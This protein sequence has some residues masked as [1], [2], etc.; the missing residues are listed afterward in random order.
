MVSTRKGRNFRIISFAT[1]A[2]AIGCTIIAVVLT[3]L[4]IFTA[5]MAILASGTI[6]VALVKRVQIARSRRRA[7]QYAS[8]LNW[9]SSE[10]LA[11]CKSVGDGNARDVFKNFSVQSPELI[12]DYFAFQ[13]GVQAI[14][15]IG[16]DS[17]VPIALYPDGSKLE[18]D[19]YQI[20]ERIKCYIEEQEVIDAKNETSGPWIRA[21]TDFGKKFHLFSINN[22]I[23]LAFVTS[24]SISMPEIIPVQV[25]DIL[26]HLDALGNPLDENGTA[27]LAALVE[28][29]LPW[30]C[31]SEYYAPAVDIE[32]LTES[33]Q[34]SA[35]DEILDDLFWLKQGNTPLT[36]FVENFFLPNVYLFLKIGM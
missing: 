20:I 26:G 19:E 7:M 29:H 3:H 18:N 27:I 22:G 2:A 9:K 12:E 4:V 5:S 25:I 31:L 24:T 8:E 10:L 30:S 11:R 35:N 21:F 13:E 33:N 14:Y 28:N 23:T 32:L 16:D 6:G 15:L 34:A 17:E 1:T 36:K